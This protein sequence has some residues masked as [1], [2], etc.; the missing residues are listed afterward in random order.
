MMTGT[1]KVDS[2]SKDEPDQQYFSQNIRSI[3]EEAIQ[4]AE[5]PQQVLDVYSKRTLVHLIHIGLEK[6]EKGHQ[7]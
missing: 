4:E 3:L 5:W 1:Q 6:M 7:M 2:F